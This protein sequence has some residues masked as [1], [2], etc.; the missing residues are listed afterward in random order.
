MSGSTARENRESIGIR[1]ADALEPLRHW[2]NAK[3][4][5]DWETP[6]DVR[7]AF[8]TADF[9]GDLT[10]FDVG[11][12]KYRLIAFVHYRRQAVYIKEILTHARYDKGA[13]KR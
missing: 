5:V 4:S 1:R 7:R 12:N 9:I 13:W 8:N 2:A 11:G 6:A 3:E 10:V